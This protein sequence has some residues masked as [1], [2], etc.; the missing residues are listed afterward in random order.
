MSQA[1]LSPDAPRLGNSWTCAPVITTFLYTI[2]GDESPK[3]AFGNPFMAPAFMST[4]PSLPNPGTGLPVFAFSAI[5]RPSSVPKNSSGGDCLSPAQY[6]MPRVAGGPPLI[7]VDQISFPVSGASA[8]TRL[9]AVC[10]YITS[11]ITS[12]VTSHDPNPRPRPRPAVAGP[13]STGFIWYVQAR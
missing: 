7:S 13:D 2:G 5:N 4:S 11:P 3:G 6:S 12:G 1:R 9:K 8:T 10:K